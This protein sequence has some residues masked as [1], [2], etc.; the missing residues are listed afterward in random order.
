MII[1]IKKGTKQLDKVL[2]FLQ[3]YSLQTTFLKGEKEDYISVSGDTSMLDMQHL[4]KFNCILKVE[5]QQENLRYSSRKYHPEDTILSIKNVEIGGKNIVVMA[6]PCSI[7]SKEQLE[8][9]ASFLSKN[10]I[11]VLRGGAFKPRTS[12]YSYQGMQE[13]GLRILKEISDKYQMISVSEIMDASQIS[14]FEKYVDIIQV[15]ARNMQNFS[16]L[17]QLGKQ[18]KPVLLKRGFANTI[19][20]FLLA[21]EYIM[22]SGNPN[23][24]LCERGIR[25]FEN[26]TRFTLDV[27]SIPIIK[28]I[29][30]LPIIAD[31]SHSSGRYDLVKPLAL[32][33]IAAGAD[34]LIFEIHNHPE[35]AL[36]DGAQ[37]LKFAK[38][39]N[40]ISDVKKVAKVVRK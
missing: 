28:K 14:L 3:S 12:P 5:R 35:K 7:E 32:A 33:S 22:Q 13:E 40:T 25:T 18:T 17:K 31:P 26:Q 15:G 2:Q 16:L 20:E 8:E 34:G 27:A 24:I 39:K 4:K 23:V 9:I 30:H 19:E 29:A 1:Y 11:R 6:G 37:S 38:F 10:Q 36:S 21:A